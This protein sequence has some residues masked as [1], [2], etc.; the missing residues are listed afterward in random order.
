MG[1]PVRPRFGQYRVDP[2]HGRGNPAT[3]CRRNA[4]MPVPAPHRLE[5]VD[6]F[7]LRSPLLAY[8]SNV[9]SQRGEDGI[10]QRIFEIIEPAHRYC[11]EFGAWDGKHLSN[12]WN[13][14]VN[15]DWSACL[16]EGNEA[17][18]GDLLATH[19]A[20]PRVTC[21][22]RMVQFEGPD[23]L[24]NV[25]ARAGAPFDLDLLSIDVDGTD[26]FIWESLEVFR[27]AV[28]VIEFNPTIPNDVI[29]VQA[30]DVTVN[31]GCSALAL[32]LLGKEKGYELVC[33]T[34]WNAIFVRAD[35]YPAFGLEDNALVRLYR[36]GMDGRIF[37]GYDSYVYVVGMP[38]LVWQNIPLTHD[39]FQVVPESLR[40][41]R[42]AQQQG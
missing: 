28:V 35:L 12:C 17:K 7:E 13:L 9:T 30:R 10:I 22:N 33:C 27:P 3:G 5:K 8:A 2:R 40:W 20:N 6:F 14:I 24:D 34:S 21:V 36:P 41:F 29:F 31:Q 37:H 15:H 25:L 38:R 32:V 18:Y 4:P 23:S 1:L 19:G 11:V 26:Y 39:D 16:V 42:D